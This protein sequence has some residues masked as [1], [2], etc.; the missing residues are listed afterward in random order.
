MRIDEKTF[1]HAVMCGKLMKIKEEKKLSFYNLAL[2]IGVSESVIRRFLANGTIQEY[3]RDKIYTFIKN[4]D[5]Q[6][7]EDV[8]GKN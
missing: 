7:C 2:D 5:V 3:S 6:K 1:D 8:N 4:N